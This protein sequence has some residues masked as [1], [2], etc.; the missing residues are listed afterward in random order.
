[1]Q[2]EQ[3]PASPSLCVPRPE[4]LQA[5]SVAGFEEACGWESSVQ[6]KPLLLNIFAAERS[7]RHP[8]R[9]A[10]GLGGS[11]LQAGRAAK[12][13]Q[14]QPPL[15]ALSDPRTAWVAS[16]L[17]CGML[18]KCEGATLGAPGLFCISWPDRPD[19]SWL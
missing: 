10:S 6:P 3:R 12:P 17:F 16:M 1:V 14:G 19:F 9:G 5:T 8:V 2:E 18:P 4:F 13:G 7:A 15:G 11:Y